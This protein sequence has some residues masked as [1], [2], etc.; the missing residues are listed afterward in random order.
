MPLTFPFRSA[1]MAHGSD[2]DLSFGSKVPGQDE[3]FNLKS[4]IVYLHLILHHPTLLSSPRQQQSLRYTSA[5]SPHPAPPQF[6]VKYQPLNLK[7]VTFCWKSF[8]G[9]ASL[10]FNMISKYGVYT[11]FYLYH[12]LAAVITKFPPRDQ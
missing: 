10:I 8:K 5:R 9:N 2:H 12:I 1:P 6:T 3:L 7:I 4:H 11:V